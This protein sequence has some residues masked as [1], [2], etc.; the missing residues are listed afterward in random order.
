MTPGESLLPLQ[1][2]QF[3][4]KYG[5]IENVSDKEYMSNSFHCHVSEDITP[6]E[7]QDSE[8]RFWDLS[9]GGKIQYVRYTSD[10]NVQA[11]KTLIRRA[12]KLGFYEG[13]NLELSYCDLCGHQE[14]DMDVCPKCGSKEITKISR[15]CGY[16][17]YSR[18]HGDTRLNSGK[19][20][21]IS[22]RKSM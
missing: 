13:V 3:R 1:V 19:M 12:M 15:I 9:N 4:K 21:E 20:S 17:G 11:F 14:I 16:L 7:K 18:I 6:I 22:D 10:Y 8:K 5:I 2:K